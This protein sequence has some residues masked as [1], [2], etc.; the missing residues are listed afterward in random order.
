MNFSESTIVN[1]VVEGKYSF[2]KYAATFGV[3]IQK[4]HAD[5][6]AFNTR[7]FKVIIISAKKLL[8]LVVMMH[9]T[10]KE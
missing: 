5:N 4:Y 1:K 3:K 9:T 7:V 6:S 8:L 10:E 2:E